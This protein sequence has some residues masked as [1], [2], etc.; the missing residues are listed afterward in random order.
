VRRGG[1]QR[2]RNQVE[3]MFK[4]SWSLEMPA[5][6]AKGRFVMSVSGLK[7]ARNKQLAHHGTGFCREADWNFR[8]RAVGM[9]EGADHGDRA[10]GMK[11][12]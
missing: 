4:M 1:E 5:L 10:D 2:F 8:G 6:R 3:N 9:A 11:S 12:W 7:E